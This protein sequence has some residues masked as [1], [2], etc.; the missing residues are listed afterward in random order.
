MRR[1]YRTA[2]VATTVR[3]AAGRPGVDGREGPSGA[4]EMTDQEAGVISSS[5]TPCV[6]TVSVIV[7][8]FVWLVL[9]D[10][11]SVML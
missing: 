11:R 3:T 6:G 10:H 1:R 9:P 4:G 8:V 7:L 5:A 2:A